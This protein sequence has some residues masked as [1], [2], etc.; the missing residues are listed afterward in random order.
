MS[1]PYGARAER[2]S[3]YVGA[4]PF[5]AD[6]RALF[7]GRTAEAAAVGD[8]WQRHRVTLLHGPA[9]IGK[10]SLL[11]AGVVPALTAR[12]ANVLPVARAD[13]HRPVLPAAALPEQN[14][15]TFALLSSWSPHEPPIR[16][17]GLSIGEFLRRRER[18]GRS[19]EQLPTL[20]AIDG[21]ERFFRTSPAAGRTHRDRQRR[22]ARQLIEALEA[23]P[24]THLL[25]SLRD[26]DLNAIRV[27]FAPLGDTAV[28]RFPLRCLNGE[29]AREAVRGPLIA[30][31]RPV[32]PEAVERLVGE[33]RAPAARGAGHRADG[34]HPALLQMA[35]AGIWSPSPAEPRL[36][37]SAALLRTAL[38]AFADGDVA[39]AL[40]YAEKAVRRCGPG[41]PR[42]RAE[43][44]VLLGNIAH[45]RRMPEATVRHYRAAA[46]MF[47]TLQ[48][49]AAVGRLLSAAG[50]V[51]LTREA[52]VRAA[53]RELRA[54]VGRAPK[55][56][57]VQTALGVALWYAGQPEAA[58]DVLGQVL[59]R[60][61]DTSEALR[62]RGEIL[63]DLGEVEPALRDLDR[64]D[65]GALPSAQA[66]WALALAIGGR[67]D[68]AR[69]EISGIG[70]AGDD[71]GPA[72]FRS[73]RVLELSGE[74]EAATRLT[75]RALNASR[76]RLPGHQR[77]A[78]RR[79]LAEL[80]HR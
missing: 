49:P 18:S 51:M 57:T 36:P 4:R 1:T 31:G 56:L 26:D 68:D 45:E 2:P 35:C 15:Y 77:A 44:E 27:L 33:I 38:I 21:G 29:A 62:S 59:H 50:Q 17:C 37:E 74:R 42:T 6:D 11:E 24:R 7:F 66:A 43:A 60:E 20:V 47:E 70:P 30:T 41:D 34:V 69:Q 65:R 12:A 13:R 76:P 48:D 3:P 64:I 58:L 55:D 9:G 39:R 10:T 46:G 78:A 61:G 63:A 16:L 75:A 80:G 22:F 72:L 73:A 52:D 23:R 67:V 79:L 19:G 25:V 32:D 71:S 54:A 53:V 28:A 5:E 8:L 14:P 40:L